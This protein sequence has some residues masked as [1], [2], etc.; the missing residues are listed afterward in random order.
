MHVHDDEMKSILEMWAK[1]NN[2]HKDRVGDHV[3]VQWKQYHWPSIIINPTQISEHECFNEWRRY[4]HKHFR[5]PDKYP[6]KFIISYYGSNDFGLEPISDLTPYDY[7]ATMGF[8]EPPRIK[9]KLENKKKLTPIE[10]AYTSGLREIEMLE[11]EVQQREDSEDSKV[12]QG[13]E[14]TYFSRKS[15]VKV[16]GSSFNFYT[17]KEDTSL[18]QRKCEAKIVIKKAKKEK[19]K[20]HEIHNLLTSKMWNAS[21]IVSNHQMPT[22]LGHLRIHHHGLLDNGLRKKNQ[23]NQCEGNNQPNQFEGNLLWWDKTCF[24]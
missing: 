10:E 22:N 20:T 4:T 24:G 6:L 1:G 8:L 7:G 18:E 14:K 5:D 15:C 21:D 11:S 13:E 16:S 17:F 23:A 12:S 9:Q 3:F 19:L 2:I